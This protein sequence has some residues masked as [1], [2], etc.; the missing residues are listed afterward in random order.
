[1]LKKRNVSKKKL[2]L[3]KSLPENLKLIM[4]IDVELDTT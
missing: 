2:P 3:P 4:L 1:M